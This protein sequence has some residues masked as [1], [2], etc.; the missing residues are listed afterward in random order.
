MFKSLDSKGVGN[1]SFD[2]FLE[3]ICGHMNS[4]RVAVAEQAFAKFDL[5]SQGVVNSADLHVGFNSSRHPGVAS[6]LITADE[7]FLEFLS[8][9][10]DHNN[11]GTITKQEWLDF[12]TAV[13]SQIE[14]DQIF[15]ELMT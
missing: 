3:A 7:A 1:V 14:Q 15:V 4:T 9:F 10:A 2:E 12:Y 6:G 11:D 8:S 13:S 5:L